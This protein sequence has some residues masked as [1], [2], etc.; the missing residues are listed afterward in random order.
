MDNQLASLGQVGP[1]CPKTTLI[2][3]KPVVER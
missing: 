2:H 3:G 1:T